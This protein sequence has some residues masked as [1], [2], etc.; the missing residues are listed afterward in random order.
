M[1]FLSNA[2]IQFFRYDKLNR[3]RLH[4]L[5]NIIQINVIT[6]QNLN[7][8]NDQMHNRKQTHEGAG[9]VHK[10]ITLLKRGIKIEKPGSNMRAYT[11]SGSRTSIN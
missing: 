11:S 9:K 5:E 1:N 2:S 3:N 8:A 7:A 6:C 4:L 10:H